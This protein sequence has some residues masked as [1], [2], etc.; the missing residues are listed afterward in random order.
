MG[1]RILMCEKVYEWV[2]GEMRVMVFRGNGCGI[3]DEM[4]HVITVLSSYE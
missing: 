1:R 3:R 4:F 2:N